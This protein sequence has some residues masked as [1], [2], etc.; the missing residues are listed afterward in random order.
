M[1]NVSTTAA[2]MAPVTD[3][4]L[5]KVNECAK[6]YFEPVVWPPSLSAY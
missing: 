3:L 2:E 4:S 6:Y 1:G 5:E